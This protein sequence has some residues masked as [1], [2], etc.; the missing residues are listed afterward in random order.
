MLGNGDVSVQIQVIDTKASYSPYARAIASIGM[1]TQRSIGAC[2]TVD[3][4]LSS[5]DMGV[6]RVRQK[7]R[8]LEMMDTH[9]SDWIGAE[10][11]NDKASRSR[12]QQERRGNALVFE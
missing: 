9:V 4:Y 3:M 5:L 8:I 6:A 10:P 2:H 1:A 11:N 12:Y 7:A